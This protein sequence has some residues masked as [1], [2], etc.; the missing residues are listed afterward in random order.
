M[1]E[2]IAPLISAG[3]SLLSGSKQ[4]KA[5]AQAREQEYAQQKEFAQ[6]GIQWKVEDAKKAGIHPLYALG[7]NT[8]SYAPQSVGGSDFSYMADAGQNIGRAIDATRSNPAKAAATALTAVQ[9][10]GLQ[11][12]NDIKRAQLNSA[13]ATARQA[14]NPPGL[15]TTSTRA[16]NTGMPGQG[17]APQIEGPSIDLGKRISPVNTGATSQE[18]AQVPEVQFA[19][20]KTG[21]APTMP[22]QLAES[23]EQD[24]IGG[25]QWQWRNKYAPAISTDGRY[26]NPP[27]HVKLPMGTEWRYNPWIGEWQIKHSEESKRLRAYWQRKAYP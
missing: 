23:Y 13:L 8:V 11:L 22:Q 1:L 7:A 9:L 6:S 19:R 3:A 2:F 12:D 15:P 18:Y 10:E 26:F 14:G 20:T 17:N 5:N 25:L 21:W 16:G 4:N 24:A 27:R